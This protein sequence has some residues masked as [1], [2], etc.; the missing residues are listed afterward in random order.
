[1]ADTV[2]PG[3]FTT[4]EAAPFHVLRRE[5]LKASPLG[6]SAVGKEKPMAGQNGIDMK[7]R[8]AFILPAVALL[9]VLAILAASFPDLLRPLTFAM[10]VV[11]F[12]ALGALL[13][14]ERK[15]R[16]REPK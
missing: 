6:A 13:V 11:V 5:L 14:T 3:A 12:V 8:A 15:R 16:R 7:L 9:L 2:G 1:M 4:T 10:P